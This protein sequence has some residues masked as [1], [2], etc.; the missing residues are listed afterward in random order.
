MPVPGLRSVITGVVLCKTARPCMLGIEVVKAANP[1]NAA[2]A[3]GG[4]IH[5][6][7]GI[8]GSSNSLLILIYI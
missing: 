7:H 8:R 1:K 5:V 2:G 4:R 6:H 3:L